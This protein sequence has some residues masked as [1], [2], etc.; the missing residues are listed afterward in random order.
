MCV[1]ESVAG[2]VIEMFST[3][4]ITQNGKGQMTAEQSASHNQMSLQMH[5]SNAMHAGSMAAVG[6]STL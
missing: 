6:L 3:S 2:N 5:E 4:A 1:V